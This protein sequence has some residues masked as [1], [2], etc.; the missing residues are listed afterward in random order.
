MVPLHYN[1]TAITSFVGGKL[2]LCATGSIKSSAILESCRMAF[3]SSTLNP[4]VRGNGEGGV[5][6]HMS[7]LMVGSTGTIGSP[8]YASPAR[9][10]LKGSRFGLYRYHYAR[11][12]RRQDARRLATHC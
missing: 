12:V 7:I 1:A 5:E 6:L 4:E 2:P 10:I 9:G 11:Y 3:L 8:D